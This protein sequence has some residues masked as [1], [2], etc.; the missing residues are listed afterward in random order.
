[1]LAYDTRPLNALNE[2]ALE[3]QIQNQQRQNCQHNAGVNIQPLDADV[4][5]F[6]V[7]GDVVLQCG[8]ALRQQHVRWNAEQLAV[9]GV[10]VL[11]D[12][13]E[14]RHR[15][16]GRHGVDKHDAEV[17]V[18]CSRAVNKRR[19][20]DF[21]GQTAEELVENV[22]EQ[23]RAKPCAEE[24]QDI[25]RGCLAHQ[26]HAAERHILRQ[27]DGMIRDDNH[28]HNAAEK[29]LFQW[30]IEPREAIADHRANQHL[31]QRQR[32]GVNQRV[33]ERA[34]IVHLRDDRRVALQRAFNRDG[35]DHRVRRV[36]VGKEGLSDDAD[37]RAG[38]FRCLYVLPDLRLL[39]CHNRTSFL[40]SF[41]I[42]R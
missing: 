7:R 8:Q 4:H 15:D 42:A 17:G 6:E 1:M 21:L 3:Q 24:R 12:Q 22:D 37:D 14:Y 39:Q 9:E 5:D 32:D 31:N 27:H 16:D 19:F 35:V 28:Q 36:R 41:H 30:E 34:E 23:T 20:L 26:A 33:A 18:P 2:A 29:Q 10:R 25:H 38:N 11:P 40:P 13:R